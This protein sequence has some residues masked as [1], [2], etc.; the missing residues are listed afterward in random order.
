M[1][2]FGIRGKGGR[3]ERGLTER[4]ADDFAM[5]GVLVGAAL[6]ADEG[7]GEAVHYD[8]RREQK[9]LT[10]CSFSIDG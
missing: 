7:D 3:G 9:L 2:D 5:A 10:G 8:G 1:V 4:R 6:E